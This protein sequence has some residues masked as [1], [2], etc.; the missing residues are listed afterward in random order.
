MKP[1]TRKEKYYDAILNGG[2][3]PTPVTREEMY[4]NEI[5]K[6]GTSGDGS[7]DLSDYYTKSQTD[8]RIT[9]KVAEIVSDAPEDLDTLKELSDWIASHEDSAAA[10]NTAILNNTTAIT[11]KADK[12]TTYTKTE[13]ANLLTDKVNKESGKG[14]STNDFTD[15]DKSKLDDLENYN[16]TEINA[17]ISKVAS[18]AAINKAAL[19]YQIKNMLQNT[20]TTATISGVTFTV[21]DDKSITMNGTASQQIVFVIYNGAPSTEMINSQLLLSGCDDGSME[22]Y[23][24]VLQNATNGFTTIGNNDGG[25]DALVNITS[26]IKTIRCIIIVYAGITVNNV[27]IYPMLRYANIIDNTYEPY[28]PSIYEQLINKIAVLDSEDEYDSITNKTAE[29]YFI[30]EE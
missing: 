23:R 17:D 28:T 27:T 26:D 22:T 14:L 30:K 13:I 1:E 18:Q 24:L 3:T 2:D 7:S 11:Q 19:G 8:Q 12:S 21:N 6:K 15:A 29:L 25:D 20:A 10:M 9:S 16:D 4:L 5:A